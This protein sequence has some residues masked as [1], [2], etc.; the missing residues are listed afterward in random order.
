MVVLDAGTGGRVTEGEPWR[1]VGD[2]TAWLTSPTAP[3]VIARV[4]S[5]A[6]ADEMTSKAL[7]SADGQVALMLVS[8]SKGGAEPETAAALEAIQAQFAQAPATSTAYLTGDAA[9]LHAYSKASRSSV[10]ST[11]WITL[12]LVVL[13]LLLVYR[14]PVSPMIP[15]VTIGLAYLI[16]RGV[17][18]I[19]GATV[20]TISG[21]TNVFLIVVLF[22]AG[23]DYCLFLISRFREEMAGAHDQKVAVKETVRTVGETIASSAGTVVVGLAT[24]GLAELGL[25]NTSGPSLAIGVVIALAAGLTL[26]PAMLAVLGDHTF[27]PRKARHLGEGRVWHAWAGRITRHPVVACWCRWPCWYRWRSTDWA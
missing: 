16:S 2:L 22:G 13:I 14:S 26:T 19:L 23:T 24:M 21:Y 20:M 10:D 7:I 15:L 8:F 11:T 17:I 6:T 5:P 12:L 25:F 27:W 18:A 9:I 4:V 1:F 3:E